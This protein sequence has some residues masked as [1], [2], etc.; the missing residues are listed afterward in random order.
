M[1]TA[2]LDEGLAAVRQGRESVSDL[3][4]VLA[5]KRDLRRAKVAELADAEA[6][7]AV[8]Q[9]AQLQAERSAAVQEAA[10]AAKAFR[11]ALDR[12][13][14]AGEAVRQQVSGL[15]AGEF[16][17]ALSQVPV[18]RVA[19]WSARAQAGFEYRTSAGPEDPDAWQ[20]RIDRP[21]D[22]HAVTAGVQQYRES[23]RQQAEA[24][25]AD[26]SGEALASQSA[27]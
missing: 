27:A 26:A 23:Y 5:A 21:A 2:Q 18:E 1:R 13:G 7:Q 9:L 22:D 11:A 14:A 20:Q 4:E 15:V 17:T 6:Q 10:Q 12:L 25:L 8:D 24:R 3:A 19:D 16:E